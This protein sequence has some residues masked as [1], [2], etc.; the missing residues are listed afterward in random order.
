MKVDWPHAKQK[1]SYSW[2]SAYS[3]KHW[4]FIGHYQCSISWLTAQRHVAPK[5]PYKKQTKKPLLLRQIKFIQTSQ[6]WQISKFYRAIHISPAHEKMGSQLY[7][8]FKDKRVLIQTHLW[9]P[10]F[11]KT[12][13]TNTWC[14]QVGEHHNLQNTNIASTNK[15]EQSAD[16]RGTSRN[17]GRWISIRVYP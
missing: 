7:I 14:H 16:F 12:H 6:S 11:G 2:I 8:S 4:Q 9:S 13:H 5:A 10:S 3:N 1:K 15:V 17:T